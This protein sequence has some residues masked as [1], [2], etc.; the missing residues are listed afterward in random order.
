VSAGGAIVAGGVAALLFDVFGTVVDW[1]ASIV[2]EVRAFAAQ[3]GIDLEAEAF[4]DAW[5]G[6]YQPSMERV[7][8][9]AEPW[10][11]LD[12]LHL[13]SL[14]QLL[15]ERGLDGLPEEAVL[16]LSLAWRR[17]DPWP[18]SPAALRRLRERYVVAPVSNGNVALMVHLARHADL[19]WDAILGAEPARAYKPDPAVYLTAAALLRLPPERC[20]MV[21]A[22]NGDLCAAGALGFRTAFVHRPLEFGPER[23]GETPDGAY[24][25]VAEDLA[26]LADRLLD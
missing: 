8:S 11:A 21:A 23:Q 13:R 17:L 7:R 9:G 1:R 6:L 16:D 20:L 3:H 10:L 4:A 26:D 15:A 2:R 19:T 18:E 22:H 12:D 5:R 14:H 25:F 24:D